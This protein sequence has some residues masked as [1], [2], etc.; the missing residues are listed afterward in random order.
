MGG[1]GASLSPASAHLYNII[2]HTK[3]ARTERSFLIT[4][5]WHWH[6]PL[7]N[8]KCCIRAEYKYNYS[9]RTIINATVSKK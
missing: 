2:K 3:P 9:P 5:N 8:E 6:H 7:P 1:D 4:R